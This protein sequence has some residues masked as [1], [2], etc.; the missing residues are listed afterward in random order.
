MFFSWLSINYWHLSVSLV[1]C[2]SP[3]NPTLTDW[4]IWYSALTS[5]YSP[6]L[7]GGK[8]FKLLEAGASCNT[9]PHQMKSRLLSSISSLESTCEGQL[10]K[11]L[12]GRF[13]LGLDCFFYSIWPETHTP[14]FSAGRIWFW[15][16]LNLH[17]P[18]QMPQKL[19]ST[20]NSSASIS[21]T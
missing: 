2:Y 14:P 8:S 21:T 20:T 11:S 15:T 3:S 4:N 17:L 13:Y 1:F 18:D 9:K 12:E 7:A 16:L 19:Y 5:A 6:K 10:S